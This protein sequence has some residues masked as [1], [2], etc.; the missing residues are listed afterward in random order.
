MIRKTLES[1]NLQTFLYYLKMLRPYHQLDNHRNYIEQA[2]L[3]YESIKSI[4]QDL[5]QNFGYINITLT[6][7]RRIDF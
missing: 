5:C 2:F 4:Y 1:H 3:N 6:I 7:Y